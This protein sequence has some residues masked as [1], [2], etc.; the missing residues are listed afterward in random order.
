[1]KL[2]N[3]EELDE[4][5]EA[6]LSERDSACIPYVRD[7]M[8]PG[9][10]RNV[11]TTLRV[12]DTGRHL[13]PVS[14]NHGH[15]HGNDPAGNS[16][17]VSPLTTYGAYA[18][19]EVRQLGYAALT[20]PLRLLV[21]ATG[22]W[23]AAAQVDRVVHVNNWLLSTNLYP[24]DWDGAD[25]PAITDLLRAAFPDHAI[26]WRSLNRHSNAAL[27]DRL[28]ALGYIAVPS[29]Q[30]YLFDGRASQPAFLKHHNCRLDAALLRNTP[31][32]VTPGSALQD[33]EFERIEHLYN[34]LYLEKYCPLNPQF[35]AGWLRAGQR[36][37][38]LQ[39]QVLRT[40]D[41][42]ID[43]VLGWFGDGHIVTAPVV[44]Y[45][46]A[47]PQS[48]GLYRLLTRLCLQHAV[49]HKLLLNFSSGAARFKRLRGGQPEIEYS[50]VYAGHL[51]PERQR[52]WKVL[53]ALLHRI[54]I[55]MMRKFKL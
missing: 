46:T 45:D 50:M 5:G 33:E 26:A 28:L 7:C 6:L 36:G 10:I 15:Q 11:H 4:L 22:C 44:G 24:R 53:S 55:P 41:G 48:L 25:L 38:W 37:G 18:D 19:H 20:W 29:R 52:V 47:L 13:L 12:L 8:A 9:A 31:Y 17:V 39:L 1:M 51:A 35:S 43:G 2:L 21:K 16:Y 42:R 49:E 34:L 27:I 40:V 23:L 3:L 54:G 32:R 14:I 30:V